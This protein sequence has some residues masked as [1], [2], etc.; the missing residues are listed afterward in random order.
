[1]LQSTPQMRTLARALKDYGG[2]ALLAKALGVPAA[3]L[4]RWLG[5]Q[6]DVPVGVYVKALDLV[7][8]GARKKRDAAAGR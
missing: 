2:E 4:A 8:G 5:G 6:E 7:S 3:D 1:M